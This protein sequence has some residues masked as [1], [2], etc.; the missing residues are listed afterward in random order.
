MEFRLN[1]EYKLTPGQEEAVSSLVEG[2]Q[3]GKNRQT[4]LGVTGS[5]KTFVMANA[6]QR[7][8]RPT[9]VLAHNKILAGQL[10]SEFKHF[11]PHNA[12]EFFVS[13]YDYY[14]PEAYLPGRD[15]YIEKEATVNDEIDR[16]RHS[17]T[18]ALLER[19]DVIVVASVSCIY[20]IGN[21][22]EYKR[23]MI[24]LWPGKQMDRDELI[25][26]LISDRYVRNDFD[27]GRNNFRVRG[28]VMDIVP[29]STKE[30][31]VRVEF[32]GDEIDRV[33]EIDPVTGEPRCELRHKSIFP[34]THF[35]TPPDDLERTLER[36]EEDALIASARFKSE[37]KVIEA[38]RILERTKYDVEMIREV[39]YCSG[40]ENYSRYFDGRKPG[41]AA[42][43]LL[44]FFPKDYMMF[45]DESHVTVPQIRGMFGGDLSR[46]NNLVGYGFRLDSAY[47][48]RPLKF[49]EFE[50]RM[51]N[52]VFVSATP[53][54]YEEEKSQ[55]VTELL[56]RPTGLLDPEV[57]VHPTEGQIDHLI[58]E[59]RNQVDKGERTLVVTLTKRMAEALTDYL[60]KAGIRVK[61]LH[62]DIETMERIEL[63]KE[64]R[65]GVF[66]VLVGI[67]LLREGLD[68]PEATL[69]AI[70]DA[71]KEGFL[72]SRTSLVQTMGRAAR[73]VN[74]RVIM[75]ADV[76]TDSMREAIN[77]TARRRKIQ[78]EYN[79]K[80]GITPTSVTKSVR[81]VIDLRKSADKP[82]RVGK[83]TMTGDEISAA[84]QRLE[85][86]MLAAAKELNFE[87]AAL[88]RDAIIE[89]KGKASGKSDS[90]KG[91]R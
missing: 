15:I 31:A 64:L 38:Q 20:S 55:G 47:D 26:Q 87:H 72:R 43:T 18:A 57:T 23:S 68:L 3:G 40:I 52:T 83:G 14:Q 65:E 56:V 53:G 80:H 50:E 88:L 79:K 32:F 29:A 25:D 89:L 2:V 84:I 9:L 48:N 58:G 63:I 86:E 24:S 42:Y 8:G 28:D 91:R 5:G 13:Y 36:I 10:C 21:P 73:N 71:D 39:G 6:I 78:E 11:F 70:L 49:H 1:S 67:N 41:E 69:I 7:L 62:H 35:I 46:K 34:A 19:E 77:E 33:L 90:K 85:R 61:Y 54:P 12:V 76:I 66:D 51:G 16:L 27:L 30:A 4:L 60:D 82:V 81:E 22:E 59:I 37:G 44:D 45:I 17:A 74:G 75:Y